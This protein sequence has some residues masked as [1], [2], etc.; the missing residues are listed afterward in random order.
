MKTF[1]HQI[2]LKGMKFHA[3]HGLIPQEKLVERLF[4]VDVVADTDFTN[5]ALNDDLNGS[6]N[7]QEMYQCI[8]KI[9]DE[10]VDL[11]ER[12]AQKIGEGLLNQFSSITNVQVAIHKTP[13]PIQGVL[14]QVSVQLTVCRD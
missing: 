11:I 13:P 2:S 3:F 4:I 1:N 7:Y 10:P 12:L 6:I 8:E 5:A 14:D 9:V